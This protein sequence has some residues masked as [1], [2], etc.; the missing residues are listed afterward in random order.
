M[1]DSSFLLLV[2]P[3]CYLVSAVLG[4][5]TPLLGLVYCEPRSPSLSCSH[6]LYF[7]FSFC[8][9]VAVDAEKQILFWSAFCYMLVCVVI[10]PS[11][12]VQFTVGTMHFGSRN[13]KHMS[14][15][16]PRLVAIRATRK[17][18]LSMAKTYFFPV[19]SSQRACKFFFLI[20]FFSTFIFSPRV[21]LF[22]SGDCLD[23]I[24]CTSTYLLF[25]SLFFHG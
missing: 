21:G 23:T 18:V 3:F 19:F 14:R 15:G 6:L 10:F 1:S 8:L 2:C 20:D 24:P 11:G 25:P 17:I 9:I 13:P 16:R 12:Q 4:S 5:P 7:S 22:Q